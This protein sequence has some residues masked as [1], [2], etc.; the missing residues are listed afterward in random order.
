MMDRGVVLDSADFTVPP[1]RATDL[2]GIA[3]VHMEA[4]RDQ[5]MARLGRRF[6]RSY[7]QIVLEGEG[8]L[9]LVGESGG[10]VVGFVAGHFDE[11]HFRQMLSA[12]KW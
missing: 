7:Y 12:R 3:R 10:Q 5:L 8:C 2:D 1:A 11:S 9:L 4:F 6:L